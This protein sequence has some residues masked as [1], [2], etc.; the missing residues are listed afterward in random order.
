MTTSPRPGGVLHRFCSSCDLEVDAESDGEC[1]KCGGKLVEIRSA[2]DDVIGTV[3]DGRFE[4]RDLLGEGGMGTVYRAWQKSVGREVAIKVMDRRYSR[5]AMGVKR[6][7]REARLASQLSQPNTVSIFDFGQA[8]DGRLFIAMELIR[9]RTLFDVVT[10]EGTFSAARASRVGVQICDALE[11]A[12]ALKIVHRDLKLENVIVLDH[13]PGRDLIK[14]LDFG[15]AKNL[16]DDSSHATQSGVVV[17]TPR[18][19]PPEA[20]MNGTA[21]RAGDL[22][23]L[24]VILGEL[25]TGSPLWVESSFPALIAGK[26]EPGPAI[27]KVPVPIK[28]IVAELIDPDPTRRP[29]AAQTRA[30]LLEIID[31]PTSAGPSGAKISPI[32]ETVEMRT[33]TPGRARVASIDLPAPKASAS[34]ESIADVAV[35]VEPATGAKPLVRFGLSEAPAPALDLATPKPLVKTP[36]PAPIARVPASTTAVAGASGRGLWLVIGAGAIA[37]AVGVAFVLGGRGGDDDA[38]RAKAPPA[39][40][41]IDIKPS[42][43]ESQP[44]PA[45][46]PPPDTPET[47]PAPPPEAITLRVI[48]KPVGATI[49]IDGDVM[50][51]S[52]LD[53]KLPRS[54]DTITIVAKLGARSATKKVK[55]DRGGD[56][57]LALPAAPTHHASGS[58]DSTPF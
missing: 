6:F 39:P 50:G 27:E 13:P 24:G 35:E 31:D 36:S 9:G 25:V 29:T 19:M 12:H 16:E 47:R 32:A 1:P 53:L 4:V 56:V 52:P 58:D 22:Y 42:P 18:Y 28:F 11:A 20:A 23:A 17:G 34:P 48:T 51:K 3:I 46:Q 45:P 55:L 2:H 7:L 57:E 33:P 37:A 41:S 54:D 10:K 49:T 40:P 26:L 21:L 30:R 43:P 38:P 5:D 8:A 44:A 15:L 14:V